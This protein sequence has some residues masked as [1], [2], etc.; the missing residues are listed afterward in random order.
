MDLLSEDSHFSA[1]ISDRWHFYA[2]TALE[3]SSQFC[4]SKKRYPYLREKKLTTEKKITYLTQRNKVE[5]NIQIS[6]ST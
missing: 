1:L 6:Y 2:Y 3:V 4:Q 5:H